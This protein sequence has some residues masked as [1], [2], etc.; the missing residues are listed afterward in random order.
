MTLN[1]V[2]MV[3]FVTVPLSI[4]GIWKIV[5]IVIWLIKNVHISIGG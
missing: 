4:F 2:F 3:L 1:G 5:E